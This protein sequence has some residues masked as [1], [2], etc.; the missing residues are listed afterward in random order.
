MPTLNDRIKEL[1]QHVKKLTSQIIKISALTESQTPKPY[2]KMGGITSKDSIRPADISSGLGM[3]YGGQTL[4]NDAEALGIGFGTKGDTPTKG[5]NLHTHSQF[6]GGALDINALQ[7]VEYDVDW[8][9]SGGADPDR[10]KHSP[11]YWRTHPPIAKEGNVE[12]IGNL[13]ITFD[14]ITKKWMTGSIYID[15]ENTFLVQYEWVDDDGNP[16]AEETP[17]A[18]R[19]IKQDGNGVEMKSPLLYTSADT[20]NLDGRNENLRKSQVVWREDDK[21][22]KLYSVYKPVQEVSE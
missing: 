12:K 17:G 3:I 10:S 2:G 8:G 11:G 13:D 5:F 21:C 15:V 6:S 4:W 7:L 14:P 9:A 16:V 1:E 19:R 22:W 18:T 20:S